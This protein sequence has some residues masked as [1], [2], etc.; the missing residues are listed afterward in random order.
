MRVAINYG[1]F[2]FPGPAGRM[3]GCLIVAQQILAAQSVA[4]VLLVV[5]D[6]T[7]LSRNIGQYYASRRGVPSRNIC[8]IRTAAT[9]DITRAQYDREIAG[10]IGGCLTSN[11][12]IEQ[13]LY[14]VTTGGVPL[15][16]PGSSEMTGEYAS[17]DSELTLLYSDLKLGHPH[18][19]A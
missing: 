9:E 16:I 3:R 14:I 2:K 18:P 6:T 7:Q 13:I 12:L 1:G 11:Q 5:N 17:V 19:L 8:H 4:N 15:K 10:A